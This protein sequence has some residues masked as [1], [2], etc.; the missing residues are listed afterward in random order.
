MRLFRLNLDLDGTH[1]VQVGE[2]CYHTVLVPQLPT[3]VPRGTWPSAHGRDPCQI[4]EDVR[5]VRT[6]LNNSIRPVY[7]TAGLRYRLWI[8]CEKNCDGVCGS[9]LLRGDQERKASALVLFPCSVRKS[10]D[11]C[12]HDKPALTCVQRDV[13][14]EASRITAAGPVVGRCCCRLSARYLRNGTGCLHRYSLHVL[15]REARFA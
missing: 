5:V 11:K 1:Q 4:R 6:C 13:Q 8:R 14:G 7:I 10:S 15:Q 9:V 2:R 3:T 12:L